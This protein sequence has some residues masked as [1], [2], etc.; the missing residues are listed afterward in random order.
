MGRHEVLTIDIDGM[1]CASCVGRAERALA[2][3]QGVEKAEVNLAT[4]AGRVELSPDAGA[5]VSGHVPIS[6]RK[7]TAEAIAEQK[8]LD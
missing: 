2:A 7:V 1:T 8:P 3:V 5:E 6:A 4:H